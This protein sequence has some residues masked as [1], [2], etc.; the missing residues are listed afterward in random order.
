MLQ[1]VLEKY[2]Y[3]EPGSRIGIAKQN[4]DIPLFNNGGI[5]VLSF[6]KGDQIEVIDKYRYRNIGPVTA[7]HGNPGS[8]IVPMVYQA[9]TGLSFKE[10]LLRSEGGV[11]YG[12]DCGRQGGIESPEI[13]RR[14]ELRAFTKYCIEHLRRSVPTQAVL[15]DQQKTYPKSDSDYGNV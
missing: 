3:L 9:G 4:I 12:P 14:E 6:K 8:E 1:T 10:C 5:D 7:I 13:K 15:M 2:F 11:L